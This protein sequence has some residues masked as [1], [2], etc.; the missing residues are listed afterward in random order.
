MLSKTKKRLVKLSIAGLACV[1][2]FPGAAQAWQFRDL[3]TSTPQQEDRTIDPEKE[4]DLIDLVPTNELFTTPAAPIVNAPRNQTI[5]LLAQ[6]TITPKP[7][8]LELA[9]LPDPTNA[10]IADPAPVQP[11]PVPMPEL[12]VAVK[13]KLKEV[14]APKK[15]AKAPAKPRSPLQIFKDGMSPAGPRE[16]VYTAEFNGV[17]AGKTKETEVLLNW[18]DPVRTAVQGGGAKTLVY[19]LPSFRQ[20]DVSVD[21]GKVTGILVHL[22]EPRDADKIANE[23]GISEFSAVPIPDQYGE[24]LGQAYPERGLL[25]SFDEDAGDD[26]LLVSAILVEPVSAEMFRLRAQYDFQHNYTQSL[27]DLDEAIRIDPTDAESFW[28]RGEI[29]DACGRTREGLK[30]VQKAIRLKPTNPTFRL[31]RGRLFA[32]TNRL[33]QGIEEIEAVIDEIELP[34]EL[35]GKAHNLL[36]DLLA[37]GPDADHQ[38]ALKNHLKAIDYASKP[39]EDRRFAVRRLAKHTLVSAHISVA[40]DIAM[41]NFQRQLEVVPKWL[42]RATDLADEFIADDQGDELLQMEIFRDTLASYGELHQGK[43]EAA[44]ATE[45]AVSIGRDLISKATD[46]LYKT[47]IERLL[48]ETLYHAAKIHRTR[49]KHV[50]A[51]QF[52]T[53]GL[54]L[55][56]NSEA[57]WEETAHDHYLQAQL[58]F[59]IGSIHAVKDS[60][61]DEA[62]EWYTK[63]RSSFVGSNF[64]TPLYSDRGHGEMY[65]SM[66][67]SFWHDD[68]D[69]GIRLTQTGAALMKEAVESG[70]LQLRA[71]SIPYGNLAAMHSKVGNS[72]KSEEYAKLVAKV[73]E[74]VKVK[75]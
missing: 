55:L 31:T 68:K 66:G 8:S 1:F 40:R 59:V 43:F 3:D 39:V 7:Q 54:A 70:S 52:A 24:V 62:I 17:E 51:M 26:S 2:S 9:P 20:V 65:V 61:H 44:I 57:A 46:D 75:R 11:K 36:G 73:E 4:V 29:L 41:G 60:D 22:Q 37:I 6:P 42:L 53:T 30:S 58:Q 33:E 56:E 67:L 74:L 21:A 49:G 27:A 45:E 25:F 72:T 63:A 71:M 19:Q 34:D 69:K 16:G 28:L 64:A 18:G 47:Q 23:L 10:P 15:T 38:S 14:P 50:S 5:D 35:A 32:K 13:P 48:A 12:N